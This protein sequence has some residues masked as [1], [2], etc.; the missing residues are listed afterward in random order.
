MY[1]NL[2]TCQRQWWLTRPYCELSHKSLRYTNF[3]RVCHA[4]HHSS[5]SDFR[6]VTNS[7][8]VMVQLSS[9][10]LI[11]R[12]FVSCFWSCEIFTI[13]VQS[14]N[15][16]SEYKLRILR[17]QFQVSCSAS[18][19]HEIKVKSK[20]T[21][22]SRTHFHE[23]WI[24]S[25]E[26][27]QVKL[28]V[29]TVELMNRCIFLFRHRVIQ[30]CGLSYITK[31]ESLGCFRTTRRGSTKLLRWI[32]FRGVPLPKSMAHIIP[33]S[34]FSCPHLHTTKHPWTVAENMGIHTIY[35]GRARSPLIIPRKK[36]CRSRCSWCFFV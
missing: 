15:I 22:F 21:W 8:C 2:I 3:R 36:W 1:K 19:T 34:T 12:D 33:R 26:L 25:I 7:S 13:T 16:E 35:L 5:V 28:N 17:N 11:A 18:L 6:C 23:S 31:L 4:T 20:T 24:Y 27:V 9:I 30:K 14:I 32:E 29:R 10:S